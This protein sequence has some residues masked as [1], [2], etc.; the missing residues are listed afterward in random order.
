MEEIGLV[1]VL[2][3]IY[4]DDVLIVGRGRARVR[5][6]AMRA[7]QALRAAGGV[8]SP[9]STLEPVTRL[10]WLGKD[11]DLGGQSVRTA[12]K[13]WEA[14]LAHWLRLSVGVCRMQCLQQFLGR[15]Q[16]ICMPRFGDSPHLSGIWARVLWGPHGDRHTV[17][18]FSSFGV[19][20]YVLSFSAKRRPKEEGHVVRLI[21]LYPRT[22]TTFRSVAHKLCV[23]L[24]QGQR[25]GAWM[26]EVGVGGDMAAEGFPMVCHMLA[27]QPMKEGDTLHGLFGGAMGSQEHEEVGG[28]DCAWRVTEGGHLGG[29][30]LLEMVHGVRRC[31][32]QERDKV[33]H[34]HPVRRLVVVAVQILVHANVEAVPKRGTGRRSPG[35]WDGR[36]PRECWTPEGQR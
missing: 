13:S 36:H 28:A 23:P 1:G 2:V 9:E 15:A 19:P 33:A 25:T 24:L 11:V 27:H 30:D 14:L 22:I 3:L 10:V 17:E 35:R 31:F 26:A 34:G 32:A 21:T 16:C 29:C 5:D 18:M 7:V 12:E 20:A 6:Q 8:M 4:I